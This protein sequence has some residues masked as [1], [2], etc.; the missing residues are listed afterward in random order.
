M[1]YKVVNLLEIQ[2]QWPHTVETTYF[3]LSS[4]VRPLCQ[5]CYTIPTLCSLEG[6]RV[7]IRINQFLYYHT[8]LCLW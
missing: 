7:R 5:H 4:A 1:G 8:S 6:I 2:T 3:L